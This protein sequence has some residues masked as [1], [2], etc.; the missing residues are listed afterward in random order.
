MSPRV[1]GNKYILP[2]HKQENSEALQPGILYQDPRWIQPRHT[3]SKSDGERLNETAI[4]R[5]EMEAKTCPV[6]G[7]T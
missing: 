6:S 1:S 5:I 3:A 2:R 4:S 7:L